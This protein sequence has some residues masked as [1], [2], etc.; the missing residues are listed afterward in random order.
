M[1]LPRIFEVI[2]LIFGAHYPHCGSTRGS[3]W[4]QVERLSQLDLGVQSLILCSEWLSK[5]GWCILLWLVTLAL[6]KLGSRNRRPSNSRPSNSL[7]SSYHHRRDSR[8]QHHPL[9][10][11]SIRSSKPNH[12]TATTNKTYSNLDSQHASLQEEED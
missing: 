6:H 9:L 4:R 12:Y 7:F 1:G 2:E 10:P 11:T 3:N 5:R 8:P